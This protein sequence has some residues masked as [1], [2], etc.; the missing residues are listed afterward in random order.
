LDSSDKDILNWQGLR[1]P[2]KLIKLL[3]ALA[4]QVGNE[5]SYN[6]LEKIVDLDNETVEKYIQLLEKTFVIFR[7][8]AFSR[9]LRKEPKRSRKIYFY[10]NGIR[11]ALIANFR[12]IELR[13]D[14]GALRENFVLSERLKF[15]GYNQIWA[16]RYFWRTQDQ[17]EI[18]YIEERDGKIYA[19]EFKWNKKA[20]VRFS[21]SFLKA[22]P[23]NKTQIITP[24]NYFDFISDTK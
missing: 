20:K 22:Y 12:A 4:L 9:N 7:L 24:E 8:T 21:K 16:N 14:I 1:K 2:E 19:F 3:Q 10:D 5:K 18:D 15:T 11:N 23:E 17:M 6:E 13:T